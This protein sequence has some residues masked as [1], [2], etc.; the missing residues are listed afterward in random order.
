MHGELKGLSYVRSCSCSR[1]CS[2]CACGQQVQA[3]GLDPDSCSL[4]AVARGRAKYF[5]MPKSHSTIAYA[6]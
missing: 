6:V 4:S 2:M 1:L 5:A 3:V